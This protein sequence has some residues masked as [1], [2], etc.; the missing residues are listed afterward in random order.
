MNYFSKYR[1]LTK[2][3][4]KSNAMDDPKD[5]GRKIKNI[6]LSIFAVVFVMIPVVVVSGIFTFLATK[7]L[8][9]IH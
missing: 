4:L 6:A 2:T 7:S 8:M 3:I 5:K 9:D 1:L